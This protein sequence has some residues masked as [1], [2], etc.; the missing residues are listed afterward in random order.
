MSSRTI[1]LYG[2]LD[3]A[4]FN[5]KRDGLVAGREIWECSTAAVA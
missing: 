4:N 3:L 5:G 2:R 1:E